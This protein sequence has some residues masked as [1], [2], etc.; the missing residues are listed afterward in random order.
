MTTA[1]AAAV[2][3]MTAIVFAVPAQSTPAAAAAAGRQAAW[4]IVRGPALA[5]NNALSGIAVVSTRSAWAAG[6]QGFSSDGTSPGR[7]LLERWNGRA[8]SLS[9]LPITWPGGIAA[10]SAS[11]AS[12]GWVVGQEDSGQSEHVLH[13]NGR[14]WHVAQN[15][16]I[17]GNLYGDLSLASA[18]GGQTWLSANGGSAKAQIFG[19]TGSGWH[20]QAYACPGFSCNLYQVTA[21]TA[22]D[23]WAVGNYLTDV[24]HGSCLALHWTGRRWV[25]T[26]IPY[27]EHCYLTSVF[28]ASKSSAWAVGFVFGSAKGVLYHWTRGTWHRVAAPAGLTPPSLGENSRITGDASARLWICDFGPGGGD[29][30]QYLFYNGSHWSVIDGPVS[31]TQTSIVVRAVAVVPRTSDAWSVG[32]GMVRGNQARA[33]I[34]FY[35]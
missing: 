15:P 8:W 10:V 7:P 34:E 9:A 24:T 17:R 13:W 27:L 6:I 11:S 20:E 22:D 5:P 25:V 19:W 29:Q 4:H 2:A 3:V 18:P 31:S 14:R 35:G 30:A 33:R 32:L 16:L 21:R 26:R 28:A 12:D 23:A 1:R